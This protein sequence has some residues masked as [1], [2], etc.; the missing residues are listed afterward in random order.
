M[1]R[2]R[3]E[4]L[5]SRCFGAS[6]EHPSVRHSFGMDHTHNMC[7]KLGQRAREYANRTGNPIGTASR[8]IGSENW[9]TCMGS[10]ACSF[11]HHTSKLHT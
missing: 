5:R 2:Q 11:I 6:F 7:C 3:Q 9:S 4:A 10:N 1:M 8:Q